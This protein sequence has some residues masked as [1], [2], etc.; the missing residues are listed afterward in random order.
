MASS[1]DVG[2]LTGDFFRYADLLTEDEWAVVTRVREFLRDEVAPVA[3]DH[4]TR[5]EFPH[6]L[7]PGFAKLDIAALP[8][9]DLEGPAARR[10]LVGFIALEIAHVDPR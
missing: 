7:V 3:L 8:Y 2:P 5:A 9:D 6:H 10:L 4:W 1:T